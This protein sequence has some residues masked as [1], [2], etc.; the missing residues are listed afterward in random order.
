MWLKER[1]ALSI[2]LY[3]PVTEYA[4]GY[5]ATIHVPGDYSTIQAFIEYELSN[6]YVLELD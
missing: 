6:L 3:S 2:R 1:D 4:S 5:A